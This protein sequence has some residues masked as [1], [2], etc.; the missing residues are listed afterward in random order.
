MLDDADN[1]QT[2]AGEVLRRAAEFG[3]DQVIAT[4]CGEHRLISLLADLPLAVTELPDD[5][6]LSSQTEFRTWAAG[7]KQLRM[8]YFYR[9]MRRKTGLLMEGDKPLGGQWNFDHDNRK[10]AKPDLFRPAPPR[11]APDEETQAVLALV[12]LSLIHI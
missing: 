2:I 7:R 3:A 10:P 6:F 8:E 12:G 1:S 9:D 4:R 11:F 5:R